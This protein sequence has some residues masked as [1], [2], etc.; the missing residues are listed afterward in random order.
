L[1]CKYNKLLSATSH[2]TFPHLSR[3]PILPTR[4]TLRYFSCS[5]LHLPQRSLSSLSP[6][7]PP[8]HTFS[9]CK[10]F[11]TPFWQ[12]LPQPPPSPPPSFPPSSSPFHRLRLVCC[13]FRVLRVC[14]N[15]FLQLILSGL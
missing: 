1:R 5:L 2:Q 10:N 15:I 13:K 4:T 7:P 6:R 11:K 9:V 14:V 3:F 8:C 12:L